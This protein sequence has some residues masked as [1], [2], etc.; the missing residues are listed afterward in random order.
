MEQFHDVDG[1]FEVVKVRCVQVTV[2]CGRRFGVS[3]G[4]SSKAGLEVVELVRSYTSA[5]V[6]AVHRSV[7][8][9][10]CAEN[11]L[12]AWVSCLSERSPPHSRQT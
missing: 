11:Q 1:S 10:G 3:D 8:G 2:Q 7:S 4:E 12:S 9:S 6:S 5:E